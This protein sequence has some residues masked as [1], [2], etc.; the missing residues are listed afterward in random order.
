MAAIT[1]KGTAIQ[2]T[3][4]SAETY[5]GSKPS[6][7]FETEIPAFA[8]TKAL[9]QLLESKGVVV[10]A[11]PLTSSA[12]WWESLLVGFGPT[13]LFVGL[14]FLF[15]RKAGN[16]Q[17]CS[18]RSAARAHGATSLRATRSRSPT[19]PGSTRRRRS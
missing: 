19:S 4:K 17:G 13:L 11:Q 7:L 16:V 12:P 6:T 8:D 9:S 2:G 1:S 5:G 18:A 10:N 15:L 14:L 3:F